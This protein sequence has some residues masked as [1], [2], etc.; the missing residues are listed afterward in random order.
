MVIILYTNVQYRKYKKTK[1][2]WITRTDH[3]L[4][5]L[6]YGPPATNAAGSLRGCP[7]LPWLAA[8]T[9]TGAYLSLTSAAETFFGRPGL[10]RTRHTV[11]GDS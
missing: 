7:G 4:M 5:L 1:T 8:N 3:V 11:L 10:L 2:G 9:H 6:M